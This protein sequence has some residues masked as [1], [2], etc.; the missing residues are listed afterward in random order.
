[1]VVNEIIGPTAPDSEG[2]GV[3]REHGGGGGRVEDR[4]PVPAG[5][6]VVERGEA[7]L[8]RVDPILALDPNFGAGERLERRGQ[9]RGFAPVKILEP[10]AVA[11]A[12]DA[13]GADG[14]LRIQAAVHIK[15]GAVVLPRANAQLHGFEIAVRLRALGGRG[16]DTAERAVAEEDR[17]WPTTEVVALKVETVAVVGLREKI[18]LP[19]A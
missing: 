1:M 18:S 11:V 16:A 3:G 12:P 13:G 4:P 8:A 9:E 19:P 6:T 17:I 2:V 10:P 14:E 7:G 15:R 5:K